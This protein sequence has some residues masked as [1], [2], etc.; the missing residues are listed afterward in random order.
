MIF[1]SKGGGVY[2]WLG[3]LQKPN[4][5]QRIRFPSYNQDYPVYLG[6]RGPEVPKLGIIS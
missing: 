5:H 3:S 1:E 4:I 6:A 2:I